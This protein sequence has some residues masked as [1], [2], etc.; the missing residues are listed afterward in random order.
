MISPSNLY[1]VF[2]IILKPFLQR[3]GQI[4]DEILALLQ[5]PQPPDVES[6][7]TLLIND[8]VVHLGHLFSVFDDSH[9]VSEQGIQ[10]ALDFQVENAPRQFHLVVLTR[11]DPP[12]HLA[13]LRARYLLIEVRARA[14]RF[15]DEEAG[16]F[17]NHV[18]IR[19]CRYRRHARI[20]VY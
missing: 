2:Y 4:G 11:E 20:K 15:T 7:L 3:I 8:L 6:L 18:L 14:L 5:S 1:I 19:R 13:R 9:L 16:E 10:Q 12:L 17:M